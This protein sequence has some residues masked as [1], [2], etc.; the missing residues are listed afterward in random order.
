M[1]DAITVAGLIAMAA[2]CLGLIVVTLY[3]RDVFWDDAPSRQ[4]QRGDCRVPNCRTCEV[5]G[6]AACD[7]C[8]CTTPDLTFHKHCLGVE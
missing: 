6:V 1:L 5:V 8:G 2:G 3:G 4:H 7:V